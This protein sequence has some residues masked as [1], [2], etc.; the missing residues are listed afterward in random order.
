MIAGLAGTAILGRAGA[1]CAADK[2]SDLASQFAGAMTGAHPL[3]GM[4]AG[5]VMGSG[6]PNG[7][8]IVTQGEADNGGA[9]DGD[10]IFDI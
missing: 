9:L 8:R 2:A 6:D 3:K 7:Q 10:T 1:A 5:L 4:V